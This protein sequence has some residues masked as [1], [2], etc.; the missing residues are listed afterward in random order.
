LL[1]KTPTI[2]ISPTT[3]DIMVSIAEHIERKPG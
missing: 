3:K 1:A 2:Y